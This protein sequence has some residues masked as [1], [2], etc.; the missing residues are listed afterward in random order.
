MHNYGRARQLDLSVG[1]AY[2]TDLATA[3]RLVEKILTDNPRV[4]QEPAPVFGVAQPR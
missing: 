2:R 1:V 4:L 3:F